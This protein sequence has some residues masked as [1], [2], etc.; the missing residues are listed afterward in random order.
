M[1]ARKFVVCIFQGNIVTMVDYS[2]QLCHS[3]T[4][5]RYKRRY[6]IGIVAVYS[7]FRTCMHLTMSGQIKNLWDEFIMLHLVLSY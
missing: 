1:E 7:V 5:V 4:D 3:N 6:D 2:V